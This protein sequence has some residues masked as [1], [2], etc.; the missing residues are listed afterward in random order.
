MHHSG[1]G[2][3]DCKRKPADVRRERLDTEKPGFQCWCLHRVMHVC[4][5]F[6]YEVLAHPLKKMLQI[7]LISLL[8]SLSDISVGFLH[9]F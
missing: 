2:G 9:G 8:P 7:K 6:L 5:N 1:I 4:F 3:S